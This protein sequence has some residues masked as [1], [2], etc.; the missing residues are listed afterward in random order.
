MHLKTP[1]CLKLLSAHAPIHAITR[2]TAH[3]T[4]WCMMWWFASLEKYGHTWDRMSLLRPG[5]IKQHKPKPIHLAEHSSTWRLFQYQSEFQLRLWVRFT[6]LT[7]YSNLLQTSSIWNISS[8]RLGFDSHCWSC[9]EV[10]G[11]LL[12][13]YCLCPPS[14]NGYLMEQKIVKLWMALAAENALN[15]P[16]RRWNR[17]RESSNTRGVNCEVCWT[18]GDIR[19]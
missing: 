7:T 1:K 11:K 6:W 16:Q 5:V 8:V 10:L 18:H 17:I 12:I 19:L 3:F 2:L 4:A 15:S 14:N 13:P 9:V